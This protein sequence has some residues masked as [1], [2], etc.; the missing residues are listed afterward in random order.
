MSYSAPTTAPDRELKILLVVMSAGID[1]WL[2]IEMD[3]QVP[4]VL[5]QEN[6]FTETLWFQGDPEKSQQIRYKFL[7][8][9]V[10]SQL[11]P[12]YSPW[13]WLRKSY[14]RVWG[15]FGWNALGSRA[16]RYWGRKRKISR[17]S[18]GSH[19]RI[20]QDLP[21]QLSLAGIRTLD[22]LQYSLK[23]FEFDYLVRLTST[24]LPVPAKIRD[25][26]DGL[27]KE[28]VYGGKVLRFV[29][30]NFVSG[31]AIFFSRDVVQGIV[32]NSDDYLYNVYEDVALGRLVGSHDLADPIQIGRLDITS[33]QRVPE[34]PTADW[35]SAPVVRC[36]FEEPVTTQSQ[37]VVSLM[38]G[39]SNHLL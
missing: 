26:I 36:K 39:I 23:N 38:R 14:K 30:T 29:G 27:P 9:L 19:Q 33:L 28:R 4:I 10:L 17:P 7:A 13:K 21:I 11:S 34:F 15:H 32:E 3:A 22:A 37:P 25:V 35:P 20:I 1:P 2:T 5:S 12:L 18:L 8:W 16:L 24:C 6:I 31:A